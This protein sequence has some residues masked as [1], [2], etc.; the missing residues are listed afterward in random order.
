MTSMP[1]TTLYAAILGLF[2]AIL[3]IRVPIKRAKLA[4]Q[5]GDGGD[6]DLSTRIRVFGNLT[7][8]L[9]ILMLLLFFNEVTGL[10]AS[11]LHAAGIAIIAARLVHALSLHAET[12]TVLWRQI[13]RGIG[14]MSTWLILVGLSGAIFLNWVN[15]DLGR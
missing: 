11:W 4:T 7:E 9:P 6:A 13:G 14:A 5:W 8:Y 3:S 15:A 2:M 1:V 10:A 12:G